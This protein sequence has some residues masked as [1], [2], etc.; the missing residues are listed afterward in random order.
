MRGPA[1]PPPTLSERQQQLY[2]L[3]DETPRESG[4][5]RSAVGA[6]GFDAALA[7]L[8]RRGLAARRFELDRPRGRPRVA[9]V[10]R[11]DA[12]PERAREFAA[13]IEGRRSSRRARAL[14]AL[15]DAHGEPLP[16]DDLAKNRAWRSRRGDADHRRAARG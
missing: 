9:E 8:T 14:R 16:F 13:S 1:D 2:D 11:L 10:A 15:L 4:E 7:A 12:A 5:L 6:R 3:L